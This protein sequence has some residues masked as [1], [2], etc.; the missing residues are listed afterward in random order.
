MLVMYG[1]STVSGFQSTRDIPDSCR[2]PH[3]PVNDITLVTLGD[4]VADLGVDVQV[5]A[6]PGLSSY[7]LLE[8]FERV[9][10]W[11]GE[12]TI[13]WG[14]RNDYPNECRSLL[15]N[16][17]RMISQ[18]TGPWWICGIP[19]QDSDLEQPECMFQ[20]CNAEL[21]A[22][23]GSRYIDPLQALG[24]AP[25]LPW[26]WRIDRV[27]PTSEANRLIARWLIANTIGATAQAKAA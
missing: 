13:L 16:Y 14:T 17:E 6:Q 15:L 18:L 27:H 12:P 25:V 5:C 20:R 19:L 22:F 10:Q 8:W 9:P 21:K 26:Y 11:H 3:T 23:A 2:A 7:Q 24:G 4:C 1:A